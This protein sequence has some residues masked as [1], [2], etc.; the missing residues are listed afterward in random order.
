VKTLPENVECLSNNIYS[1]RLG[2]FCVP[3]ELLFCLLELLLLTDT[4][5]KEDLVDEVFSTKLKF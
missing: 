2:V 5:S 4:L 1:P 3:E